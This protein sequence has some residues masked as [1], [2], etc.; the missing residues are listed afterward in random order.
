MSLGKHGASGM[1]IKKWRFDSTQ[2]LYMYVKYSIHGG[3]MDGLGCWKSQNFK[4]S[5]LI[6]Y[7]RSLDD[8]TQYVYNAMLER[9]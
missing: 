7:E 9:K 8:V 6:C 1:E 5:N 2:C 4:Q 3:D